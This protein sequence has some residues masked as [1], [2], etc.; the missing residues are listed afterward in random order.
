MANATAGTYRKVQLYYNGTAVAYATGA[1]PAPSASASAVTPT[2]SPTLIFM[3]VG[4]FVSLY[5]SADGTGVS[6]TPNG[7]NLAYM[8]V[9][10]AHT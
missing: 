2:L 5:A 9:L 4:D 3:N 1:V 8:T 6:V 7:S 10:W